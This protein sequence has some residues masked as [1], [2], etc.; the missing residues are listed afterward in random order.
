HPSFRVNPSRDTALVMLF[1]GAQASTPQYV[2]Y[3]H[4][5]ILGFCSQQNADFQ[6]LPSLPV[7]ASVRAYNGYGLL[8]CVMIGIYVGCTTLLL[9]PVDFFASPN[10]WFDLVQRYKV[11][12]AFTTLPML[13]HAMNFLSAYA[14]QYRFNLSTVH[15]FIVAT[16]ER[17]DPHTYE[18]IRLFFARYGLS[19]TAINLLYGTLMNPC[20]STRAY[21]G[22]S[23]LTLRLDIHAMR[24]A[25]VVAINNSDNQDEFG[26]LDLHTL[27][28][29][30]SGKVSGSTMVAI[31]DPATHQALPAGCIGEVWVCSDS[32]ATKKQTPIVLT[33]SGGGSGGGASHQMQ[34]RPLMTISDSIG[35][36]DNGNGNGN[37]QDNNVFVRTG[38]LG[39]LYLQVTAHE[40]DDGTNSPPAAEPY[41]FVAGRIAET[42][43]LD[44]YM[45]FYSD[46]ERAVEEPCKDIIQGNCAVIQTTQSTVSNADEPS[47]TPR[48][49]AVISLCRAPSDSFLPN[50]ACLIF[51]NVLDRHQV[52]LDEIVFVPRDA[53]PRSRISERRRRTVRGLYESGKLN[54]FVTYPITN[55][56]SFQ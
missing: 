50:A 43:H 48:L 21:L 22:V 9:S 5:A 25:K 53:L 47:P 3:S 23:P 13:Q 6:M 20:I 18:N 16:E 34:S 54:A 24:R 41:L 46:I 40:Q 30:D 39:F 36:L 52:L 32:N 15:N 14:S 31:V 4:R 10:V 55:S 19:D 11:K 45:H 56:P 29:Q 17:V 28:L 12:D 26:E 27:T 37:S 35:Y 1:T 49:V 51:N 44:G 33:N 38:D 8:H 7:I 2:S 42:F